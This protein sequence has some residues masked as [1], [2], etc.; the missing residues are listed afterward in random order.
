MA[1]KMR[2]GFYSLSCCEGCELVVFDLEEKLLKALEFVEIVDARLFDGN[3]PNE[4]LDIAIVEGGVQSELDKKHLE[5]IRERSTYLVAFGACATI[6]GIPGIRNSLPKEMQAKLNSKAI[7]PVK[8][9]VFPVPAVVKTDFVL[10]GC[11]AF[12]HELLDLLVALYHGK[13][14]VLEN[15]PV[16]KECKERE[17]PCLL[18]EGIPCLG[19]VT[20]AG[21][22]AL[23]PTERA[24][25][26][27]CRGFTEDANF[28]ALRK[29]FRKMDVDERIIHNLF[30]YFNQNPFKKEG[31]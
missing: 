16:C 13:K 26:I 24:Q 21:C 14:P 4:K 29:R 12:T 5:E 3:H 23:C 15:I 6:A 28:E 31:E 19:P 11:P 25:C 10:Q 9:K 20:Y 18:F 22:K 17:N 27:G 30:T 2:A 7:I 1:K 8:E